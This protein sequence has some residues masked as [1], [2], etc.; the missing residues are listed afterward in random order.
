[1]NNK[2]GLS[3]V[4]MHTPDE[5]KKFLEIYREET[6]R[7]PGFELS[8]RMDSHFIENTVFIRG[9]VLSGHAPCPGGK[10]LPNL[11]SRETEV[12]RESLDSIRKSADTVASFG[13]KFLVLH[14]GYTLDS[15]VFTEYIERKKV[16][17]EYEKQN[18]YLW[19][20]EGSICKR[21]YG[22][23]EEY[24]IF[25]EETLKNLKTAADICTDRGIELAV[26]NLNP[27]LTY[28]F[29]MPED[30]T[31]LAGEIKNIS[32]CIDIGHLWISSL[33]HDYDYYKALNLLIS[34]GR[35]VSTHIHDNTSRNGSSPHYSD[36]HG[37]IGTGNVPVKESVSIIIKNSSANLIIEAASEPLKNI[38]ILESM[39]F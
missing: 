6:G 33:V 16:L 9:N 2:T 18:R 29:Q 3:L 15:P 35:V 4:S 37:T 1:M 12:I 7:Y 21:G 14:A 10:Y 26:E 23:S 13:G 11:G 24:K 30:F 36:D 22:N 8:Y 34:T 39:V 27:R 38:R 17:E 31:I 28:L 19:H 32:F 20:K 25:M 5:V